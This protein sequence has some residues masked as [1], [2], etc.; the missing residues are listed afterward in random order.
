MRV[1]PDAGAVDAGVGLNFHIVFDDDRGRLRNLVPVSVMSFGEAEAVGADHD[2]VLQEHVVADAA[3]LA[4]H[5]VRVGKE[6]VADLYAAIDD[7][8][9]QQ[10]GVVADLDVLV[11]DDIRAEVGAASDL[12]RGVDDRRRMHARGILQR[13]VEEFEGARETKIRIF[14]AQHGCRDDREVLGDN[15]GCSLG[16]PGCSGVLGVGDEGEFRGAGLLDAVEAGDLFR[17][18]RSCCRGA[19]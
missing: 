3:V 19:R 16:E 10:H 7:D 2:S 18:R 15:Y 8:V 14:D 6:I 17:S 13:F 1:S 11:D 9:R 4:H 5:G 12:R